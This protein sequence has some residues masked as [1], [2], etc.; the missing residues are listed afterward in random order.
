VPEKLLALIERGNVRAQLKSAYHHT[1]HVVLEPLDLLGA[2]R[3]ARAAAVRTSHEKPQRIRPA[4]CA[5]RGDNASWPRPRR[6]TGRNRRG[7]VS[8]R[9]AR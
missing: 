5:A 1:T 6:S 2:A 8:K 7:P 4:P 9:L 3:D